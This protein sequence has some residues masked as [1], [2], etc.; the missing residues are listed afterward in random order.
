M[1]D[2]I[3]ELLRA[4]LWAQITIAAFA[5][6]FVVSVTGSFFRK[7]RFRGRF[8]AIAEALGAP[9]PTSRRWPVTFPVTI[10]GR[11]F[12]VRHALIYPSKHSS[13]RGPHGHLLITATR[14]DGDR[15][16]LHQVDIS[17]MGKLLSRMAG[18]VLSKG[19][20]DFDARFLVRQDGMKV[21]EGWLDTAVR[22][23]V[24]HVYDGI[25]SNSLIAMQEGELRV[26][27]REP[28]TGIDGAAVRSLLE[29]QTALAAALERTS[30]VSH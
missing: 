2:A 21:R 1:R 4:P 22:R 3:A 16:P 20:P 9:S 10:D 15:W 26:T 29:R 11:A 14:L 19:D 17:T 28:W 30:S 12:E 13:Y 25:P 27:L 24:T 18:G 23:Q 5:V 7:R 8:T 6:L